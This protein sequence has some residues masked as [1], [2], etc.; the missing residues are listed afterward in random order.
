MKEQHR[1]ETDF[2]DP[3]DQSVE[4]NSLRQRAG[5]LIRKE[6][7]ETLRDRR[8]I[9][10]LLAMPLL[11]YPLMGMVFRFLAIAQ[12]KKDAGAVYTLAVGTEEEA[13]WLQL[14]LN[15]G[16]PIVARREA[17]DAEASRESSALPPGPAQSE[18]AVPNSVKSPA[19]V[20]EP[21]SP[22]VEVVITEQPELAALENM[23]ASL[24]A[25]LGLQIR[26]D[27]PETSTGQIPRADV[28]MVSCRD[29][30]NSREAQRYIED[31]IQAANQMYLLGIARSANPAIRTPSRLTHATVPSSQKSRGMLGLLPLVLLLMTVTGGVY[32]AIDLTAGERERDTLETLIALPI[33]RVH[34]LIAKYVAVFTV[35][36]LTG[37]MNILAMSATVYTLRMEA[38]LFGDAGLTLRLAFSLVGIQIVFGLFYS[39]VLLALTSS[40]RSFKEAQAYLIPLMLMSI[41]PGLVILL[42]GWHLEGVIAVVPLVNMLLLAR[43]VF[44]GTVQV[45]PAAAA[46]ISTLIYAA[47]ALVVAAQIFG[48]D[49]V[50]VGSRGTWS[51][52]IRRPVHRLPTATLGVAMMTL[53]MLFPLYFFC[54]GVLSRLSDADPKNRMLTGAALTVLLFGGFPLLVA[55]WRRLSLASAWQL[56]RPRMVVWPGALV[57][58]LAAWPWIYEMVLMTQQFGITQIDPSRLAQVQ[59]LLEKWRAVPTILI[60]FSL[61]VIPGVFEELFFRGFLLGSLRTAFR[62]WVAIVLCGTI[63]GVFHVIAAEG[64]TPERLLPSATLGCLL[65]WVAVRTNSVLPGMLLHVCHNSS[66][67]LIA[68]YQEQFAAATIGGLHQEHLPTSWLVASS[69]AII[70][71]VAWTFVLTRDKSSQPQS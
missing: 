19:A 13:Q 28:R 11:L 2:P 68:R 54:N 29:S 65:S 52:L 40:S 14:T 1:T 44:E 41:A 59:S 12:A 48:T 49:A 42:P 9:I 61:G 69:V 57:L 7:R 3:S 43:D 26:V 47:S 31:R 45:L 22:H 51:E 20:P 25:D 17:R 39:A 10:T 58:G 21:P 66:L 60:V 62:P 55:V 15:F 6:L 63:F 64:A 46:V 38:Q 30:A 37:L 23:V 53:T 27:A 67:L 35:T 36:M 5:L 50:A 70:I 56:T 34:L 32:P 16:Q 71:G 4:H 33:P 18:S 8:T 24:N